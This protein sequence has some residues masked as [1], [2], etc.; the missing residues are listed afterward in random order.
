MKKFTIKFTLILLFKVIMSPVS[1]MAQT[2]YVLPQVKDIQSIIE[3]VS[4]EQMI[5]ELPKDATL[6]NP[7]LVLVNRDNLLE[8]EPYIPFV[9][10]ENG[11]P[12]HE[13]LMEPL[14]QM[15]QAAAQDGFYYQ[16]I[17]GY[18]SITEQANN[19]MYRYNSYLNEGYSQADAQYWTD[20][21][22]APSNGSEHTT[23][24]A[25]DLL[26]SE[27]WGGLTLDYAYQASAIWLAEHAHDYGFILRYVD[28]K[29][30]ITGINFEP[31]HFRYVGL[32]HAQF[33]TKHGLVLEEY[34]ALIQER[35]KQ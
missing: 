34:L 5:K 16:F 17:S 27:W 12:Y 13:V 6:D 30:P 32:D 18:R 24:L 10:S 8:T 3:T 15:R 19:R 28:G 29:T 21:F 14:S 20:L 35:D 25:V 4:L 22:Y 1:A 23:G 7:L 26:G 2:E 11:M 9:Y 31:W 33:M